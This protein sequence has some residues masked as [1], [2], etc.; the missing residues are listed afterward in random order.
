METLRPL[1]SNKPSSFNWVLSLCLSTLICLTPAPASAP[2]PS[3]RLPTQAQP[4]PRLRHLCLQFRQ[5]G[6]GQTLCLWP[7]P[8]GPQ[9]QDWGKLLPDSYSP[10]L[11]GPSSCF[12]LL[13]PRAAPCRGSSPDHTWHGLWTP[14]LTAKLG[15]PPSG[16][17]PSAPQHPHLRRVA[18]SQVPSRSSSTALAA[19]SPPPSGDPPPCLEC[20]AGGNELSVHT[21]CSSGPCRHSSHRCHQEQSDL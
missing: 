9:P 3:P 14:A 17:S 20:M 1:D 5:P 2:R 11:S 6:Q 8:P 16:I 10:G 18:T 13:C 4:H 21:C 12:T 19:P 7:S 15:L